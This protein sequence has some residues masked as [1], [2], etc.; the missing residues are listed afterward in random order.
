MVEFPGIAR[1]WKV[2]WTIIEI[3]EI[4]R[5]F[6]GW[7]RNSKNPAKCR[8][9]DWHGCARRS[10]IIFH[11]IFPYF[12]WKS[13]GKIP[14]TVEVRIYWIFQNLTKITKWRRNRGEEE[15]KRRGRR[16]KRGRRR[17]KK[18]KGEEKKRG[19]GGGRER[20]RRPAR[21]TQCCRFFLSPEKDLVCLQAA[22]RRFS[23]EID[24]FVES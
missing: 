19:R 14:K 20:T 1:I 6:P 18:V 17:E 2:E 21:S 8:F 13:E 7:T 11:I 4:L 5:I 10:G 16:G 3:L 22:N 15:G 9:S 24:F 12:C 23:P